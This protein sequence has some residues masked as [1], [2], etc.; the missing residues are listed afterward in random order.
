MVKILFFIFRT[1]TYKNEL[2][3]LY[4]QAAQDVLLLTEENDS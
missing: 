1:P 2:H 4:F 3:A